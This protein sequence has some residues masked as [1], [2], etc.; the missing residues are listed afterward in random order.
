MAV[1]SHLQSGKA[2]NVAIDFSPEGC[3]GRASAVFVDGVV[4]GGI[5]IISLYLFHTEGFSARIWL[6][7][8]A[9]GECVRRWG[10]AWVMAGD[11]NMT[12]QQFIL[13]AKQ[14]LDKLQGT[15]K[16]PGVRTCTAGAV[17][18]ELD[19]FIVDDRIAGGVRGVSVYPSDV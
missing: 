1:R 5:L 15:V 7:V 6:I 11:M 3:E 12:P 2:T 4:R 14:W 16:S 17:G 9:A 8:Q 19:Y 10:G 13:G 18:R